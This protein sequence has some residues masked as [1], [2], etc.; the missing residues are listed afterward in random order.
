MLFK[1]SESSLKLSFKIHLLELVPVETTCKWETGRKLGDW[2]DGN[3][4]RPRGQR[5]GRG[6]HSRGRGN[7]GRN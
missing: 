4:G 5:G 1:T 7:R 6:G 3:R 2:A